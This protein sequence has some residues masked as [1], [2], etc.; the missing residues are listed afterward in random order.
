M[1]L[2]AKG[3]SALQEVDR[4]IDYADRND[5]RLIPLLRVRPGVLFLLRPH[6]STIR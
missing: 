3:W 5:K 1:E 4:V 2:V 6:F